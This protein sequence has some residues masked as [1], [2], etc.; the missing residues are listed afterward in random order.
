[1]EYRGKLWRALALVGLLTATSATAKEYITPTAET[2]HTAYAPESVSKGAQR[3]SK[4]RPVR[5]ASPKKP[6]KP[7]AQKPMPKPKTE[8][9]QDIDSPLEAHAQYYFGWLRNTDRLTPNDKVSIV[10]YDIENNTKVVSIN[11]DTPRISAST[12]K[13]Y[14]L[15]AFYHQVEE[16]KI[17]RTQLDMWRLRRMIKYSDNKAANAVMRRIAKSMGMKPEEGPAAVQKILVEHYPYFTDTKIVEFIPEEGEEAG[18]ILKTQ[19]S[20][21]DL[22]KF[23]VQLWLGNLPYSENMKWYLNLEKRDRVFDETCIPEGVEVFNKTGTLYG[24]VSDSAILVFTGPDGKKHPYSIVGII[25]DR[26]RTLLPPKERDKNY[27]PWAEAR[28]NYLRRVSE[29]AYDF[30]YKRHTGQEYIC[31][32]HHGR[33]LLRRQ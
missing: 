13:V 21:H 15:V 4:R 14:L 20:V 27:M 22:N 6:Q 7:V 29:G 12:F 18:R 31:R 24:Q 25:Q 23:Y 32:K 2:A 11:E 26:T 19:T 1:M 9:T 33:H 3:Q 16:G 28:G 30:M 17:W 10:V 8:Y 5:R